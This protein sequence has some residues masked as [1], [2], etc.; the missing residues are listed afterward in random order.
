M[1]NPGDLDTT[2]RTVGY[3]ATAYYPESA[4]TPQVIY[5]TNSGKI[6]YY[7]K[8][9]TTKVQFYIINPTTGA[10]EYSTPSL[11]VGA[12][13]QSFAISPTN[14]AIIA[15]G[16]S[17]TSGYVFA[18]NAQT[19]NPILTSTG[20]PSQASIASSVNFTTIS[21]DQNN[22][23]V[24]GGSRVTGSYS[25]F[26]L[27]RRSYNTVIAPGVTGVDST[28]GTNGYTTTDF[29]GESRINSLKIDATGNIFVAGY[30]NAN[31]ALAKYTQNGAIIALFG[32]SGKFTDSFT[33][34][35]TSTA[36]SI[37]FDS[38]NN[39]LV[40]GT[41]TTGTGLSA[42]VLA[43]YNSTTGALDST[44]GNNGKVI[45]KLDNNSWVA[46]SMKIDSTGRIVVSGHY[47]NGTNKSGLII[48]Y[49]SNGVIDTTFGTAGYVTYQVGPGALENASFISL[50][51][52][53]SYN[54]FGAGYL[55]NTSN[56]VASVFKYKGGERTI[57]P[58][59]PETP[60]FSMKSTFSDNS[61][62]FYKPH[63]GSSCGG[64]GTV[65]NARKKSYKT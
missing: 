42:I 16:Q 8:I 46:N 47:D 20:T 25:S 64:G 57:P 61:R 15:V 58:V 19:L 60:R 2:F 44:F 22:K 38:N 56:N 54:I 52:D 45:T 41:A 18:R 49:A 13:I 14:N 30:A 50:T 17:G 23:F 63:S 62:V 48:R 10:T 29:G 31:F 43:K 34:Y 28:F 11:N 26:V 24:I 27:T 3:V 39:L 12:N 21:I 36:R 51:L 7:D 33:G 9:G 55:S 6:Y 40:A 5:N 59:I 32:T 53:N 65:K 4:E 35:T 1:S 37:E